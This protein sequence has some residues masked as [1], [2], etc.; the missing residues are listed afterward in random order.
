MIGWLFSRPHSL[1]S[2]STEYRGANSSSSY[3]TA[4]AHRGYGSGSVRISNPEFSQNFES[5]L[6]SEFRIQN[7]D[8]KNQ[9]ESFPVSDGESESAYH[10]CDGEIGVE[11]LSG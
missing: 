1:Y 4:I 11:V 9:N 3:H 10:Q 6:Q 7:S 5:R 2:P 8:F